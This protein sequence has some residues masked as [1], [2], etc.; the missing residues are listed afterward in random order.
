MERE[1][2]EK[3]LVLHGIK[4]KEKNGEEPYIAPEPNKDILATVTH[5]VV[6][7]EARDG[8]DDEGKSSRR[9]KKH[10]TD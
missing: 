4:P 6:E 9:Q 3:L 2:Y 1:E 10:T 8:K 7:T 5:H